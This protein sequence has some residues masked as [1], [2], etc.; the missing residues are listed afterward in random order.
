[1][2]CH[3]AIRQFDPATPIDNGVDYAGFMQVACIID[4][5]REDEAQGPGIA[6]E[7]AVAYAGW[8]C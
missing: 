3:R 1:M 6:V 8:T 7:Q 4:I 5:G 2:R